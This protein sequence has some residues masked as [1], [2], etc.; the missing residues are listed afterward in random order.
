MVYSKTLKFR[1]IFVWYTKRE[2]LVFI[3]SVLFCC[4]KMATKIYKRRRIS[5]IAYR[6]CIYLIKI[7]CSQHW[8]NKLKINNQMYTNQNQIQII[9]NFESVNMSSGQN[10]PHSRF[11]QQTI[12]LHFSTVS[13]FNLVCFDCQ[14]KYYCTEE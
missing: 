3:D 5:Y 10:I 1:Q 14:Q 11:L 2:Y 9:I 13:I 6:N 7:V 4:Y 8:L 12:F